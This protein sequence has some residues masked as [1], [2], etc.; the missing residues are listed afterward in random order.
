MGEGSLHSKRWEVGMPDIDDMGIENSSQGICGF[1]ST[2]YAVYDNRPQLRQGLGN[3]L[4]G[5]D[6]KTRMMAEIK[7]FLQMM[8]AESNSAVLNQ[9]TELTRTF[10][11]YQAWTVDSYIVADVNSRKGKDYS[12]VCRIMVHG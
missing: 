12:V 11:R 10:P 4:G 9:I 3:A 2:L 5:Q 6:R 8:K 7:T 1:T